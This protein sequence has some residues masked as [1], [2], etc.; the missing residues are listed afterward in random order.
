MKSARKEPERCGKYES[1]DFSNHEE[2]GAES[3]SHVQSKQASGVGSVEDDEYLL[4]DPLDD[5]EWESIPDMKEGEEP[6][7][8]G[9][10][11]ELRNQGKEDVALNL[12]SKLVDWALST[13]I[14]ASH[15]TRLLK[16]L[17]LTLEH[18]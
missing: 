5:L 18:F 8:E 7:L 16:L 17:P 11:G 14:P 1:S 3:S 2:N 12:S 13:T 6:L 4:N 10:T 9:N 15:L